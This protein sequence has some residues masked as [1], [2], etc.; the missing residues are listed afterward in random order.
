MIAL[1]ERNGA[2]HRRRDQ[3]AFLDFATKGKRQ[4]ILFAFDE[5]DRRARFAIAGSRW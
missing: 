2:A 5:P 4:A 1:N 3:A